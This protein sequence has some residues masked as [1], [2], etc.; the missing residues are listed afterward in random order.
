MITPANTSAIGVRQAQS[1][2][3]LRARFEFEGNAIQA[4]TQP[5]RRRSVIEHVA[6]VRSAARAEDF[7]AIHPEAV[8]RRGHDISRNE[9]FAETGPTRSGFKFSI[10]GEERR[11]AAD[12]TKNAAAMLEQKHGGA[13]KLGHFASQNCKLN[14]AQLL[15]PVGIRFHNLGHGREILRCGDKLRRVY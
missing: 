15:L 9:R 8:I 6:E 14:R 2:A 1:A 7:F 11:T 4:I 13:G 12:A 5:G 3:L 10:A